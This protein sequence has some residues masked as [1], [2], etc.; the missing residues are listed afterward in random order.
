MVTSIKI[1]N[2]ALYIPYLFTPPVDYVEVPTSRGINNQMLIFERTLQDFEG[3]G[4]IVAFNA[5]ADNT[6]TKDSFGVVRMV[7]DG[8]E[9][10]RT[11]FGARASGADVEYMFPVNLIATASGIGTT[12]IKIYAFNVHWDS[13]NWTSSTFFLRSM[14][15]TVSGTRR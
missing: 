9:S 7:L 11:R 12:N 5:Y 4:Y 15:I 2:R 14:K 3:G 1:G 13:E 8:V 6:M 10:G